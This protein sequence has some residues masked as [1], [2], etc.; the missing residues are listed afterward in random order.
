MDK[1]VQ[2]LDC[3]LRD[4]GLGLE[5]AKANNEAGLVFSKKDIDGVSMNLSRSNIDIV[6]IGS[7]E[8][9]DNDKRNFAIYQNLESASNEIPEPRNRNQ[10]YAALYR[11]PD[12]PASNIPNRNESRCD[13]LRVIIRY[14]EL[15]K[16]LDF[17]KELAK[18][19]Y[20]VFVQPMVT[21]RYS[22]DEL[23]TVIDAANEMSAYALYFVDSYGY[24]TEDD[25]KRFFSL[26]DNGL[27][28]SIKIGFHA[29]NN[30][31]LAFS[32]ALAFIKQESE[33]GIIVDSCC[34]GM[35]QGAGNLQTEIIA[36]HLNRYHGASYDYD[37]VLTAC[38]IIEKYQSGGLWGYSLTRF[39]PAINRTAYKYSL[40]FRNKYRLTFPEIHKILKGIPEEYRHRY[41][42]ENTTELLKLFGY[43]N[44][45]A[46]SDGQSP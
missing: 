5:D 9:S 8:I 40:A 17:C 36:D 37:A 15:K 28:A 32:N 24:M 42:P 25:V 21:A 11:G 46:K 35:G 1:R 2:L 3:T 14:S 44:V 41:T 39:L 7:I 22:K 4:G 30:M 10:M 38:E 18:K 43:A 19:D 26:Y 34:L 6:E 12:T 20:K 27:S 33:R 31:N 13:A 16:S 45:I 29:H 23:Q